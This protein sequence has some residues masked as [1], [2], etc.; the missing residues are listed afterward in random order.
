MSP[1]YC[2]AREFPGAGPVA[3]YPHRARKA[4]RGGGAP[5]GATRVRMTEQPRDQDASCWSAGPPSLDD[6]PQLYSSLL[7]PVRGER[8]GGAG[9]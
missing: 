5:I 1:T 9:T 8:A 2:S 6:F 7:L 4:A 3:D